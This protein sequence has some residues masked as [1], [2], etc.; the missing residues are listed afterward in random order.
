MSSALSFPPSF[1]PCQGKQSFH[2]WDQNQEPRKGLL[3]SNVSWASFHPWQYA[4]KA[5]NGYEGL[6]HGLE[7]SSMEVY[8]PPLRRTSL[9]AKTVLPSPGRLILPGSFETSSSQA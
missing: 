1:P 2:I 6:A 9:E 7:L 4:V 5:R 8:H 3:H